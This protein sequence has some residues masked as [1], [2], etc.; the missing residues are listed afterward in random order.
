MPP[1]D[2]LVAMDKAFW[3]VQG[4]L[5]RLPSCG[6]PDEQLRDLMLDEQMELRVEEWREAELRAVMAAIYRPTPVP[7]G[8]F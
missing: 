2:P 1:V 7:W 5:D 4:M 3:A 8:P 6:P